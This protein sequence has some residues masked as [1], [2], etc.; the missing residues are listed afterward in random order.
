MAK[1]Y[2]ER[3]TLR[4]KGIDLDDIIVS[5]SEKASRAAKPVN[6]MNKERVA[7]GVK[8]PNRG[9][10]LDLDCEQDDPPTVDWYALLDSG[11]K[12]KVIKTPSVG[13]PVTWSDCVVTDVSD[14]TSDGDSGRKVSVWARTRR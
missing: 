6:T 4:I 10:S 8:R 12:F 2:V 9:Y 5:L 7:K 3:L 13:K 14:S 11:E 1:E